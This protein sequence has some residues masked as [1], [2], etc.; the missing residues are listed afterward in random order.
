MVSADRLPAA[1]RL[2]YS[3]TLGLLRS[4]WRTPGDKD[5]GIF[6]FSLWENPKFDI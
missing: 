1:C 3:F 4:H 6:Q 2:L 5:R